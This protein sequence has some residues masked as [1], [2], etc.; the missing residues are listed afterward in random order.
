MA[1]TSSTM[2]RPHRDQASQPMRRDLTGNS[3]GSFRPS[4][5]LRHDRLG[6]VTATEGSASTATC[7]TQRG[8]ADEYLGAVVGP[9]HCGYSRSTTVTSGQSEPQLNSHIGS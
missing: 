4:T 2:V 7:C 5:R 9:R 3:F 8:H 1:A 6:T